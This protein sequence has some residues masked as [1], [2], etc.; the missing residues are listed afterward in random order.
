MNA[1]YT[2]TLGRAAMEDGG[3][4]EKPIGVSSDGVLYEHEFGWTADGAPLT[5]QRW[6]KTGCVDIMDGERLVFVRRLVPDRDPSDAV[7]FRLSTYTWPESAGTT[8]PLQVGGPKMDFRLSGRH[9]ALEVI[10]LRDADWRL[11]RLRLDV[12]PAGGR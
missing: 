12:V 5:S 7:G 2:G 10:G 8:G 9:V 4:F 1:W 3:V 6:A 11:G